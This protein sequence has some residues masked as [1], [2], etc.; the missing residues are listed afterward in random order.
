MAFPAD[1]GDISQIVEYGRFA[2]PGAGH[3]LTGAAKNNKVM[4]WG[5]LKGKYVTTG[6]DLNE[7][8]GIRALG[9]S[10]VDYYTLTVRYA[11]SGGTTVPAD[12]LLFLADLEQAL[13][14]G[15]IF[16]A[17]QVGADSI[18]EPSDGDIITIDYFIVGEDI[19]APE[20]V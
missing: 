2:I 17:D 13:T 18:A 1:N 4:V 14:P 9:V 8:G 11:G 15:K 5:Q 12:E 6:L 10:T 20:L 7:R 3:N 19:T 16:V